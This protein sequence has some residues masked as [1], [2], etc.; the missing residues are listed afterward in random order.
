[1]TSMSARDVRENV[2]IDTTN[3]SA[4]ARIA[5]V[6]SGDGVREKPRTNSATASSG[7]RAANDRIEGPRKALK[8]G[9]ESGSERSIVAALTIVPRETRAY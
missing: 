2:R 4:S 6:T 1:V 3:K 5:E 9:K 7:A 8:S